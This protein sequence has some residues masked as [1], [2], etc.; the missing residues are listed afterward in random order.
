MC[1]NSKL[2]FDSCVCLILATVSVSD[3]TKNRRASSQSHAITREHACCFAASN[4][5]IRKFTASI[6]CR[7]C[8]CCRT[9]TF[10]TLSSDLQNSHLDEHCWQNSTAIVSAAQNPNSA[11]ADSESIRL[12]ISAAT[13]EQPRLP[14]FQM[15]FVA[16]ASI[17]STS[18]RTAPLVA[19][20]G[21]VVV[22]GI[23]H[24]LCELS[25]P[26]SGAVATVDREFVTNLTLRDSRGLAAGDD[27]NW[28]D[29]A[30]GSASDGV[31]NVISFGGTVEIEAF[32]A[33]SSGQ[34][35]CGAMVKAT[36]QPGRLRV[37]RAECI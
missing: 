9:G 28:N 37:V 22:N 34:R 13:A 16:D 20:T 8:F 36:S 24:S 33:R 30:S 1:V 32:L 15:N 35:V 26:A 11:L 23:D 3:S 31:T 12:I 4:P 17:Y 10:S 2:L 18:G 21:R 25:L 14:T 27:I 6:Q 19:L 29:S 7:L 5:S